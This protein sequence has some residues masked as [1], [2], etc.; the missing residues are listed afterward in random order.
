MLQKLARFYATVVRQSPDQLDGGLACSSTYAVVSE[1]Q[2]EWALL[3]LHA[4][5]RSWVH[6]REH[7]IAPWPKR[8]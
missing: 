8:K 1:G 3:L 7:V 5:R 4:R 6:V 2:R